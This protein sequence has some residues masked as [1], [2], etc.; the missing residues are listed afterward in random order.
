VRADADAGAGAGAGER[1][2]DLLK[3]GAEESQEI[4]RRARKRRR[5]EMQA[6]VASMPP[7]MG[8]ID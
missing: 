7:G 3:V 2:C 5:R 8:M 1:E 6:I 4:M